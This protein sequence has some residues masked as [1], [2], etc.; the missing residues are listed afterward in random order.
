[1]E[2]LGV[3]IGVN[4]W[5]V[6]HGVKVFTPLMLAQNVECH[7]INTASAA[8]LIVGSAS[9]PYSVT[10]HAVGSTLRKPVLDAPTTQRPNQGVGSLPGSCSD[11][12]H[13]CRAPEADRSRSADLHKSGGLRYPVWDP[14][15]GAESG[16]ADLRSSGPRFFTGK[17]RSSRSRSADK[18]GGLIP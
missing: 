11:K 6:I 7:I 12:H 15:N 16:S 13:K 1:M 3:G 4:L 10:K 17:C 14:P 9:A 8:G 18:S 2:R 5:G